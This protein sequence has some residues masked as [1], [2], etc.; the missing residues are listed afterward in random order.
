MRATGEQRIT[1]YLSAVNLIADHLQQRK[2][3]I[4][5]PSGRPVRSTPY[6]FSRAAAKKTGSMRNWLPKAVTTNYQGSYEREFI[7]SRAIDLVNSDPQAAGTVDT[8]ATTVVGSGLRVYPNLD[9]E[10]LGLSEKRVS[11]IEASEIS[12]FETW[13]PFADVTGR[14]SFG[15]LQYL[16]MRSMVQFGEY[17]FLVHMLDDPGR[18]YM[19][20]LQ[21]IHPMRLSTPGDL[22]SQDNIKDG[23][24]IDSYGTPKAYWIKTS[25]AIGTDLSSNYKRIPARAGHRIKVLHGYAVRDPEQFRGIS[26]LAPAMKL[27]RDFSDYL[28]AEL[29]SNIVTSA[30][31]LF[32]ATGQNV[33]PVY[34]ATNLGT[35][36]DTATKSDGTEYDQRYQ[37]LVPGLIMYGSEGEQPHPIQAQRPGV[38]FKPFVKVVGNS[39]AMALGIPYPVLFKD[40]EG[41]NFASYRSAM[42]EAWRVFKQQRT[43]LGSGLCQPVYRMLIEEAY[44]RGEIKIA[45]F[46]DRLFHVTKAEW[47]GPAKGQIEPVKE[48]QGDV[49]AIQNNLKSRTEVELEQNRDHKKTVK[50]LA[51][52]QKILKAAGLDEVKFEIAPEGEGNSEGEGNNEP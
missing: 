52:E 3:Q 22:M 13:A 43:W 21:C 50:Q 26:L 11:K 29:V 12:V 17:L 2:I 46:Y 16:A 15:A 7:S 5:D 9:E 39:I 42:L 38:T 36:T 23:I 33:D 1:N 25:D 31:S 20:A 49:L 18:P 47:I 10:V 4:L 34:P 19:I 24:E 32:I 14:L 40:F 27:Y 45:K 41:M 48:T 28:D 44:L 8:I 51:A 6:N 35:I 30:F 37:E